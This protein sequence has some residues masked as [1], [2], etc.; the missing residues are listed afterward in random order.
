VFEDFN[1]IPQDGNPLAAGKPTLADTSCGFSGP[2]LNIRGS[3]RVKNLTLDMKNKLRGNNQLPVTLGT[4]SALTPCVLQLESAASQVDNLHW[5]G[6]VLDDISGSGTKII[7]VRNVGVLPVALI[8]GLRQLAGDAF[9]RQLTN[10]T[11]TTQVDMANCDVDATYLFATDVAFSVAKLANVRVRTGS[12][13]HIGT[14]SGTYR[15]DVTNCTFDARF[16]RNATG[17][18]TITVRAVASSAGTPL[19]VDAGTPS[20]RLG[21]DWDMT[22]DGTLLDA[23][24]GNHAAK[25]EFYNSN[26]GFGAGVGAYCRGSATWVRTAA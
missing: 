5:I 25:A 8:E 1:L 26:A 7:G 21:G 6:G 10:S 19:A 9:W 12:G 14:A 20:I 4:G 23:T 17:N 24:V 18:N 3:G 2:Y 16:I 22:L 13:F 15:V 11:N